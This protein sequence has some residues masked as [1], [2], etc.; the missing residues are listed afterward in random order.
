MP[1]APRTAASTPPT[2]T[3]E[4]TPPTGVA[5][6]VALGVTEEAAPKAG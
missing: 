1:A 3:P 5:E 2:I 6:V 4:E